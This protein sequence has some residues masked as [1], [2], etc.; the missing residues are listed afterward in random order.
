M[1]D[2]L[3]DM[4]GVEVGSAAQDNL[5]YAL[6]VLRS[7]MERVTDTDEGFRC[8]DAILTLEEMTPTLEEL[9]AGGAR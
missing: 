5:R 6:E 9:R 4:L 1:T 8:R 3:P 2:R 7:H